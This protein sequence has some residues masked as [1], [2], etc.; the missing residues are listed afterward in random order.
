MDPLAQLNDI[1][2]PEQVQNWPVAMGWW[3]L[4]AILV[5]MTSYLIWRYVKQKRI[6]K[7]KRKALS[8]IA[9]EQHSA[10][11]IIKILKWACMAYFPRTE[12]ANK[13]GEQLAE[14]LATTLPQKKQ[15]DF[16]KTISPLLDAHYQKCEQ[17]QSQSR[18]QQQVT[19]WLQN[20]L[21]PQKTTQAERKSQ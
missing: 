20:A 11:E 13:H 9:N 7:I 16:K 14:F 2:L 6:T 1:H 10:E 4:A 12:V 19:F 5:C 18:L 8:L 17:T 3:L 15:T 21:P